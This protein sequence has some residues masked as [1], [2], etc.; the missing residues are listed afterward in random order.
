MNIQEQVYC[1][2]NISTNLKQNFS[3]LITNQVAFQTTKYFHLRTIMRIN[4]SLIFSSINK[5]NEI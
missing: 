3:E 5:I 1:S 2:E 4:E